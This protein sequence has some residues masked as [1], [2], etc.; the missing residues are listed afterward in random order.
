MDNLKYSKEEIKE[1]EKALSTIIDDLENLWKLGALDKISVLAFLP[2]IS[3]CYEDVNKSSYWK[4]IIDEKGIY[5]SQ[6]NN[7]HTYTFAK[8]TRFG[9]LIKYLTINE[10]DIVFINE[11][12]DL[13]KSIV[14]EIETAQIKKDRNIESARFV[15]EL[16]KKEAQIEID[17]PDSM[18]KHQIE[19]QEEDGRK[20]GIL[21][22]GN[23]S[24]KIITRG[25]I[26]LVQKERE[27]QKRK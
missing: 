5:L 15:T 13:R 4:F 14:S 20:I 16:C 25:N 12:P 23:I 27:K 17:L 18:N 11:Y 1:L 21:N 8:R 7:Q 9:K 3:A 24:L 19:V 10:Q 2:G 6:N 26:E 22:F